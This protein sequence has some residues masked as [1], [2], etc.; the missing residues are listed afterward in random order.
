MTKWLWNE[1]LGLFDDFDVEH[2]LRGAVTAAAL[3]PLF[4]RLATRD[5]ARRTAR[6]VKSD[7]L[8]PGGLLATTLV[9][10]EQWDAPNG[11]APCQWIA[12]IGLRQY[13]HRA[14]ASEIVRRWAATV[15]RVY[16]ET[17]RLTE[18]YDVVTSAPGGGGE[19]ALQDGFGWTNGV[20]TA[21]LEE[22][23]GVRAPWLA[24]REAVAA[25][26]GLTIRTGLNSRR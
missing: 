26:G 19:Y 12:A 22:F 16:A 17:G 5:Q 14:L 8:A 9:T 2:G 11:W 1:A 18:K 3:A 7:L 24:E 15:G 21:L 13:G 20:T 10:G 25:G 6:R 23:P 4:T